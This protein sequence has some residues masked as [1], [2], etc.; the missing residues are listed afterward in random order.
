MT[1]IFSDVVLSIRY[2]LYFH[3][4]AAV[5]PLD[6]AFDAVAIQFLKFVRLLAVDRENSVRAHKHTKSPAVYNSAG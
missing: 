2:F 1:A 6:L 5:Q 3:A 4:L